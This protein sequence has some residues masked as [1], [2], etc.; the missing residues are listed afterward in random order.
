M[1]TKIAIIGGGIGGLVAAYRLLQQKNEV[2]IFE[3]SNQLGG[4]L[5][6]FKIEGENLEKTYH[7]IFKTDKEF[8]SLI[9]ELGLG[10]KLKWYKGK[11]GLYYRKNMYPFDGAVDLLKFKPLNL[12]DKLRL[13]TM[14]IYLEKENNWRKFEKVLAY[15]WIKK[16]CG[17]RAYKIVWEPLLKGKFDDKYKD[18]SMAWMWARIHTRGNSAE[19]GQE[20]L[21]YMEG[22][23]EQISNELEKRI[24]KMGGKIEKNH[25]VDLSKLISNK[26]EFKKIV[27][28]APL[29][30]IEYLGAL[31][32]VFSSEQN[33]S[34]YYWHN[35]NDKQSPFVVLVQHTN[36]MGKKN[37]RNKNIYYLG[38]YLSQK[39]HYLR[40]SE[41]KIYSDFFGYLK[42]IFPNF[43]E[44]DIREK[45]VFRYKYAQHIVDAKY[46]EKIK[47]YE[48]AGKIIYMNF[49]Q[50]YPEDRG[51]NYAVK[52]AEDRVKNL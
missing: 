18:I 25:E 29:K 3:K 37:Y 19:K 44:K 40:D 50:I 47:K 17:E 51:V 2:T 23:F 28:S 48:K 43:R 30:G 38:A 33:L 1:K 10:K 11:T 21:G 45:F 5:G 12:I 49:A 27:S 31:T 35:I 24:K 15:K 4:L 7:H 6:G 14:K 41:E 20:L 13:G 46:R 26:G 22:G 36:L 9:E 16:W 42:K 39:H 34:P 52:M 8:I 32:V